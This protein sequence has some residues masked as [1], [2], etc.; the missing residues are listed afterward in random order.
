MSCTWDGN[1]MKYD[2][3][4]MRVHKQ[5]KYANI[6]TDSQTHMIY[7]HDIRHVCRTCTQCTLIDTTPTLEHKRM[8]VRQI[9]QTLAFGQRLTRMIQN[10]CNVWRKWSKTWTKQ[11]RQKT[12][13]YKKDR[14]QQNKLK[15][16]D[17][18]IR[19]RSQVYACRHGYMFLHVSTNTVHIIYPWKQ[20]IQTFRHAKACALA[21]VHTDTHIDIHL[22]STRHLYWLL[23]VT[24]L[25][26]CDG[27]WRAHLWSPAF[28]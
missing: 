19:R 27:T 24:Y 5:T 28:R 20:H 18:C 26:M 8:C 10:V 11:Q 13:E 22:T 25:F 21:D 16:P 4:D 23:N 3:I 6:H 1:M 17:F 9:Q 7:R 15:R 14:R 12:L 2:L